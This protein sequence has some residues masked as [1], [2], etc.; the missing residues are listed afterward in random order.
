M[1]FDIGTK[2]R[3]EVGVFFYDDQWKLFFACVTDDD[4]KFLPEAKKQT[5]SGTNCNIFNNLTSPEQ[6]LEVIDFIMRTDKWFKLI[7]SQDKDAV[8]PIKKLLLNYDNLSSKTKKFIK[9]YVKITDESGNEIDINQYKY[10]YDK[11]NIFIRRE[12]FVAGIINLFKN[13]G[14]EY[15]EKIKNNKNANTHIDFLRKIKSDDTNEIKNFEKKNENVNFDP[16]YEQKKDVN[17]K[18]FNIND[19]FAG[20]QYGGALADYQKEF[21]GKRRGFKY[22]QE[23]FDKNIFDKIKVLLT[24]PIEEEEDDFAKDF[25]CDELFDIADKTNWHKDVNGL[26][27]LVDNKKIYETEILEQLRKN[28]TNCYGIGLTNVSE[29]ECQNI[30]KCLLANSNNASEECAKIF[31][32]FDAIK[33]AK[34]DLK[35]VVPTELV[36]LLSN[37][38]FELEETVD[39]PSNKK[40]KK[41]MSVEKWEREVLLKNIKMSKNFSSAN[42]GLLTYLKLIVNYVN[43]HP[44]ILNAEMDKKIVRPMAEALDLEALGVHQ[45]IPFSSRTTYEN[46]F[47]TDENLRNNT[48]VL[49]ML[50]KP[51]VLSP[52][53]NLYGGNVDI[54]RFNREARIRN[55]F[56]N[57]KNIESYVLN[58]LN[59]LQSKGKDL[60]K[61]EKQKVFKQIEYLK[62]WEKEISKMVMV[63]IEY[64]RLLSK[65]GGDESKHLTIDQMSVYINEH[66]D[67]TGRYTTTN[68]KLLTAINKITKYVGIIP[69]NSIP[70]LKKLTNRILTPENLNLANKIVD[71]IPM[72]QIRKEFEAEIDEEKYGLGMQFKE[73]NGYNDDY[74]Y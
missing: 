23:Q 63:I 56:N 19:F 64:Y 40:I 46:D 8:K 6:I 38:G 13:K 47:I 2:W 74:S 14:S 35:N 28:N 37:L 9:E 5:E 11:A 29:N 60:D 44:V 3:K 70:Q 10:N 55:T 73:T 32:N 48:R 50:N 72:E 43:A 18:K 41:F 27:K 16:M 68:E 59:L 67:L 71:K 15:V 4:F 66:R 30:I 22:F 62:Q 36:R 49:G 12:K 69:E 33:V 31:Q 25:E 57:S 51:F 7:N 54:F 52:F 45:G 26:Y 61:R 20:D 58:A 21:G 24:R 1:N 17:A 42:N 34:R 53:G 65:F 39:Y